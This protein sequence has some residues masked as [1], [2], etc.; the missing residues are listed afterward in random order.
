MIAINL[1]RAW[2]GMES[3]QTTAVMPPSTKI[4]WP[5]T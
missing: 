4:V 5:L 1:V 2:M 3:S